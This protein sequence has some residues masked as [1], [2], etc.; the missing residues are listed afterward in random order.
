MGS[1]AGIDIGPSLGG[2]ASG[3]GIVQANV[4][5][6]FG[7]GTGFAVVGTRNL[8]GTDPGQ[9]SVSAGRVGTMI[10]FANVGAAAG[11]NTPRTNLLGCR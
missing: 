3:S 6:S 7:A 2:S 1:G 8:I 11:F 10:G 9:T 5:G 4:T